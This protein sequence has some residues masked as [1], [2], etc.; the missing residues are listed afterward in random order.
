MSIVTHGT[1]RIVG[2]TRF[3]LDSKRCDRQISARPNPNVP[4]SYLQVADKRAVKPSDRIF[5]METEIQS[6]GRYPRRTQ[7]QQFGNHAHLDAMRFGPYEVDRRD[8]KLSK[9][10]LRIKLSGQPLEVLL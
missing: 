10:G 7:N 1:G 5:A 2:P 6:P 8:G 9:H 3:P 4:K